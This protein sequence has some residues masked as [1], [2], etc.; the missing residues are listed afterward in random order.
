MNE[1]NDLELVRHSLEGDHAAFSE[2][3]KRYQQAVA[4][5]AV[6]MLGSLDDAEEAGQQTFIRL[7]KSLKNFK[8]SSEL[9]TYI[10]R[11]CINVCLSTLKRQSKYRQRNV[12]LDEHVSNQIGDSEFEQQYE[13]K[14]LVTKA[15]G[16]LDLKAR[17]VINLRMIQ[18]Y[19]TKET[20]KILGIAEGTVLSRLKRAMDKLKKILK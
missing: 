11:I 19:S 7:Y 6:N 12:G 17:V 15:L 3:V 1:L 9:K 2:I 4:T 5:T 20:A 8:G 13:A 10:T 16:Q 14:Q 18:G